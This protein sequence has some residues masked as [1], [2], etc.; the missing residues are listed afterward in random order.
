ILLGC[1]V[2]KILRRVIL[3]YHSLLNFIYLAQYHTY[4]D[5][6]LNY[7]QN[8]LDIFYKHMKVLIKLGVRY[9]FNN[10]N[11]HSLIHYISPIC[12]FD[13]MDN[14]NTEVFEHLHIDFTKNI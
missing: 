1:L 7:L 8:A 2:R 4:N 5:Q 11:I 9:H 13:V 14:Y 10:S 3:V 12:L 6:T